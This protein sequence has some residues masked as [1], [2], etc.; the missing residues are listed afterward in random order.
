M[1]KYIIAF[2][3]SVLPF[4]ALANGEH[5]EEGSAFAD[6][7]NELLPMVHFGEAHY[8]SAIVSI[9]LWL[10]LIYTVYS[11]VRKIFVD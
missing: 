5:G 8:V 1:R 6:Q 9:I 3:G 4:F 11:L 2:Y 7:M 10:A